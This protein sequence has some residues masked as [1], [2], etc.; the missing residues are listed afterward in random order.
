MAYSPAQRELLIDEAMRKFKEV[1]GY[2]P[3]T[4]GG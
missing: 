2:Y 1:F 3:K 4:V